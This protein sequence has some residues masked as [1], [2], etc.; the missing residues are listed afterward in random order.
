MLDLGDWRRGRT[1]IGLGVMP[2]VAGLAVAL[3]RAAAS[4]GRAS[5]ASSAASCSPPIIGFGLYTAVKATY[6]SITFATRIVG[7]QPHLH[8]AAALH[9]HGARGSN[10]GGCIRRA[11]SSSGL[12]PL[13]IL[14]TPYQ[15]GQR[16]LFRRAGLRDP[17]AGE[18]LSTVRR[19]PP[20]RSASI[21]LLCLSVA[22]LLAP[23][24][25]GRRHAVARARGCGG[26]RRL[27]RDRRDLRRRGVEPHL[28]PLRR[29]HSRAVHVGRRRDRRQADALPRPGCRR[30]ERASGC[31]SSGTARSRP[32]GASTGPRRGPGPAARRTSRPTARSTGASIATT[33]RLSDY[34]VE[35]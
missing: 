6:L 29:E 20:R 24:F 35:D 27:E 32:C 31:S 7:A 19:R 1:A 14:D 28:G 4:S 23:R 9:R 18:P 11:R 25:F 30:S 13:L 3:A 26:S 2:F 17:P 16:P 5:C 34:V 15:M 10:G 8:R 22:L 21:A 12:R 33:R